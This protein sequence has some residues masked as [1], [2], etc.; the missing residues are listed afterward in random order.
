MAHRG[1]RDANHLARV[2]VSR[3]GRRSLNIIFGGHGI[4]SDVNVC[5][6]LRRQVLQLR[7]QDEHLRLLDEILALTLLHFAPLRV[8]QAVDLA[9]KELLLILR[10]NKRNVSLIYEGVELLERA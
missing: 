4:Q 1:K 8:L 9:I 6:I 3:A 5:S 10:V 7:R 2:I